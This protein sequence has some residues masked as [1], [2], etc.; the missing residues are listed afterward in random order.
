MRSGTT[1]HEEAAKMN[2]EELRYPV[3]AVRHDD[4]SLYGGVD[5]SREAMFLFT[6]AEKCLEYIEAAFRPDEVPGLPKTIDDSFELRVTI[7]YT[8]YLS[9]WWDPP[10]PG[11]RIGPDDS[12]DIDDR[13]DVMVRLRRL[14]E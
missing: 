6:T 4:G 8:N 7:N 5:G 12:F 14:D 11:T 10:L 1:V 2:V 3:Y 13:V 9:I